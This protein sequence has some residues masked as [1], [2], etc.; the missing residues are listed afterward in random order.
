MAGAKR[1]QFGQG[2]DVGILAGREMKSH[3]G[4]WIAQ[5]M[6]FARAPA[7]RPTGLI[8]P[9]APKAHRGTL[10]EV[11]SSDSATASVPCFT[12]AWKI[13]RH[14]PFLAHPLKRL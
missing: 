1:Q 8:H 13:A 5:A 7:A 9:F 2:A 14:R 12:T 11:E 6:D 10:T 3:S 4:R